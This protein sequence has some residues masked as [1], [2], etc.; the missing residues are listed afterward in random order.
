MQL[1]TRLPDLFCDD[2]AFH[3]RLLLVIPSN[4]RGYLGMSVK[5]AYIQGDCKH[6]D[7]ALSEDDKEVPI[8]IIAASELVSLDSGS[9]T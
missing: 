7:L 9:L 4:S 2:Y 5:G 8:K 3:C 6:R 1:S